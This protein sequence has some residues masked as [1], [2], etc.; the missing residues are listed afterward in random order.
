MD[1]FYSENKSK[2]ANS[3]ITQNVNQVGTSCHVN[4]IHECENFKIM[5]IILSSSPTYS[6]HCYAPP[7]VL[8]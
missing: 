4:N 8:E 3:N 1:F 5:N 2:C 7:H 6:D